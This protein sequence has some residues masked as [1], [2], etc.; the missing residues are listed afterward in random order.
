[1]CL[2]MYEYVCRC[3]RGHERRWTCVF[4]Y[5][6]MDMSMCVIMNIPVYSNKF[7]F[8][9]SKRSVLVCVACGVCSLAV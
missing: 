4:P 9:S 2:N 8:I 7:L 5:V 3:I 6:S 1:M